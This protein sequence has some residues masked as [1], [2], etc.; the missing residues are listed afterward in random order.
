MEISSTLGHTTWD[1][2]KYSYRDVCA[3]AEER[4]KLLNAGRSQSQR[5][6]EL[7][8]FIKDSLRNHG[9]EYNTATLVAYG[10]SRAI[11]A[12]YDELVRD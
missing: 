5:C 8:S 9:E 4:E 1:S 11:A 2:E 6:K 10:S 12:S 3:A 7:L